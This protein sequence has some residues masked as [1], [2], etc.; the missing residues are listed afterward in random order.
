MRIKKNEK[1]KVLIYIRRVPNYFQRKNKAFPQDLDQNRPS[2]DKKIIKRG[3]AKNI[4]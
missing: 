4:S 2:L 3:R 1:L